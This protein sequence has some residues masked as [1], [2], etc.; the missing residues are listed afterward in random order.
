MAIKE[1]KTCSFDTTI[2]FLKTFFQ[3]SLADQ[4]LL[5]ELYLHEYVLFGE[6]KFNLSHYVG[7]I[8]LRDFTSFVSN[9][10]K[11]KASHE[12]IK[13]TQAEKLL[14]V[15]GNLPLLPT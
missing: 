9:Q 8:Q 1:D 4:H 14:W 7:D 11:W 3:R 12:A 13:E 2:S 5:C 15:R 10:E 6:R